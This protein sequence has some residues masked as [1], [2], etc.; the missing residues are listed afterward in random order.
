MEKEKGLLVICVW[1]QPISWGVCLHLSI[2]LVSAEGWTR[3]GTQGD[4]SYSAYI[5]RLVVVQ[6]K[7]IQLLL[8]AGRQEQIPESKTSSQCG[9]D[10]AHRN[11]SQIPSKSKSVNFK[12][13]KSI[14]RPFLR[15]RPS[16]SP[17]P[18]GGE[19]NKMLTFLNFMNFPSKHCLCSY[20]GDGAVDGRRVAV[21]LLQREL[22]VGFSANGNSV[23]LIIILKCLNS[24][25]NLLWVLLS[26]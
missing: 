17:L 13:P 11:I 20:Q 18:S 24:R 16:L 25:E 1:T 23:S 3:W 4:W 19:H 21:V 6:V 12:I 22:G 15:P 14:A 9:T 5:S 2:R 7:W 8:L 10:A 26:H